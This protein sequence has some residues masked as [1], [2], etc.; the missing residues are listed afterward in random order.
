MTKYVID[1]P[2]AA[3]VIVAKKRFLL[4]ETDVMRVPVSQLEMYVEPTVAENVPVEKRVIE[5][6]ADMVAKVA[7][8]RKVF[9]NNIVGFITSFND[10]K[11]YNSFGG[12][13][14]TRNI[15]AEYF[16]GHVEFVPKKE[17]TNSSLV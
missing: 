6:P 16:N 13:E 12:K 5:L 8:L 2:A 7:R 10:Q 11:F 3:T 17:L 4:N 15:M 14:K 1:L 9:K